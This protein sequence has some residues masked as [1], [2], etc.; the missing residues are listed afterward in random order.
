MEPVHLDNI[1]EVALSWVVHDDSP[2]SGTWWPV[3]LHAVW[4]HM[5]WSSVID[6][7]HNG[8][9]WSGYAGVQDIFVQWIRV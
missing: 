7:V 1:V 4:G 9:S 5:W 6:T 2:Q 8:V 3:V